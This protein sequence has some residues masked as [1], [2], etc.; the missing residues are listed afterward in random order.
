M[1]GAIALR[2]GNKDLLRQS[3]EGWIAAQPYLPDGFLMRATANIADRQ[4]DAAEADLQKAISLS[5]DD[6]RGYTG[7]AGLRVAEKKTAEAIKLYEQALTKNPKDLQ[8]LSGLVQIRL[9]DKQPAAAVARIQ[10]QISTVPDQPDLYVLLGRVQLE[11]K[12]Y[13]EAEKVLSRAVELNPNNVDAILALTSAQLSRG[14][15][16]QAIDSYKRA[17]QQDPRDLRPYILLGSLEEGQGHWQDAQQHYQKALDI[18]PDNPAAANNLAY[19]LLSH[20]GNIDVALSLAETA[21]RQLPEVPNTADTLAWAYISKGVYGLAID[22]LQE[23][24]NASPQN[25]TYHYH[26]GIA[27]QKNNDMAHAKEQF[28]KALQLNPAGTDIDTIRKALAEAQGG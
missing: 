5:P 23:A 15:V 24:V 9:T 7:L 3:A 20:N 18:Q 12:N 14:S 19:L 26:L 8:A 6:S 13:D 22:L 4:A 21:R 2:K 27:Y 17:I 1:R 28:Q 11:L 16:D 25:A 10:Q